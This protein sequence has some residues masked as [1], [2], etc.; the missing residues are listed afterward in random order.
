MFLDKRSNLIGHGKQRC[1]LL[2]IERDGKAT[3]AID[4]HAALPADFEADGAP[5]FA[6]KAR[7]FC[8]KGRRKNNFLE[9][10]VVSL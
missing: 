2:L 7:I 5:T 8:F 3:E 10:P 4:R 6:L 9:V 1:P